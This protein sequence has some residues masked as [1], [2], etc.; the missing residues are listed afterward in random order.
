[1]VG[2]YTDVDNVSISSSESDYKDST[3]T[4][5]MRAQ[6]FNGLTD[7]NLGIN[8]ANL[9]WSRELLDQANQHS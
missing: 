6:K 3:P 8:M 9:S 2:W 7:I 4:K 5:V 1:M